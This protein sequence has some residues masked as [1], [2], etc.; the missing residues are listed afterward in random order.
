M[1]TPPLTRGRPQLALRNSQADGNTPAYAGKTE[2]GE[3][4]FTIHE[5][6]P[7]LRGE[8]SNILYKD[9]PRNTKYAVIN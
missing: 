5:K 4:P 9:K 3:V 1:E 7:R 2:T 8:D 6:H